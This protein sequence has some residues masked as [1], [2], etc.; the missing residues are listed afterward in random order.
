[1][2]EGKIKFLLNSGGYHDVVEIV[3]ENERNTF[4]SSHAL[5]TF[6]VLKSR[7]SNGLKADFELKNCIENT[8]SFMSI[9]RG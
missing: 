6:V 3:L 1:M 9:I 8:S 5:P 4:E 2:K 7:K